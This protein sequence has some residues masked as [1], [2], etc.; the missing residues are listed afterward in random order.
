MNRKKIYLCMAMLIVMIL[1]A[2]SEKDD[3][4][5]NDDSRLDNLNDAEMPIVKETVELNF[6]AGQHASTNEDWND[7]MIFNEY[8]DRTNMDIQWQMVPHASLEEKRNISLSDT[9][10]LPDAYHSANMPVDDIWKY[11]QQGVFIPLNDLIDEY[12]PNMKKLLEEDSEFKRAL[13][14]PDG[15]IYSFPQAAD[16]DFLSIRIGAKPWI[17]KKWLE[18]LD[19]DIPETTEEFYEYLKAA[20][21]GDPRGDGEGAEI[22]YGGPNIDTLVSYLRGSFGVANMGSANANID[23]DPHTEELRFYPIS[24]NYKQLLEYMH[25]LYSEELIEGNIFSIEGDQYHTNVADKKYGSTVW[26]NTFEEKAGEEFIGMPVLEGPEGYDLLTTFAPSVL[27]PGAF[28]ITSANE[29]PEATVRWVDYFYGED[30]KELFFMGLEGETFEFNDDGE[31]V[32]MD[33]I[34]NSADGLSRDQEV[35]KYLTTPGGGYPSIAD[36]KYFSGAEATEKSMAVAEKLEPNLVENA[37]SE[38]K[39]LEDELKDLDAFGNDIDK[40][41]TEMR[42]KFI[43]GT[44][45]FSN[46]DDYVQT[47]EN[48]NLEGYM[49]I[50]KNA[51]E[52]YMEN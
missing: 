2:C 44:E 17:N 40:Y 3:S 19:M 30:G 33:H 12:A 20:K 45:D 47:L 16:P 37:W 35:K 7:V 10:S 15:N 31:L 9:K 1:A 27:N 29:H 43:A 14:F 51:Y 25:R 32:Y 6:F 41:V 26:Y 46:W 24:D 39:Y 22:P 36:S 48:M 8:K 11:G 28:L 50:Q 49:E 13:T 52:R 5:T 38:F 4:K 23:I 34:L 42:D 21:E 18:A